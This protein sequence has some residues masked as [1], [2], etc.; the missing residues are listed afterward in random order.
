[1]I[2]SEVTW[3]GTQSEGSDLLSAIERNC[4][5]EFSL[6]GTRLS[7]CAPHRMLVED[8]RALDGLVFGRRIAQRLMTEE[9]QALSRPSWSPATLR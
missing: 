2:R 7:A 3:N 5:C 8:Q 4:A 1:M 6:A 9:W